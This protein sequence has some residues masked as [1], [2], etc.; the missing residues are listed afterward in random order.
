MIRSGPGLTCWTETMYSNGQIHGQTRYNIQSNCME[1]W[2][3]TMWRATPATH[4]ELSQE[5]RTVLEWA[6]QAMERE[7]QIMLLATKNA[8]VQD[9]VHA[10]NDIDLKLRSAMALAQAEPT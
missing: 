8:M 5:V 3:G 2:D 4:I 10:R 9:L 7:Q 6:H 1:V